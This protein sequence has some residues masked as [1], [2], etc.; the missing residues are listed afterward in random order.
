MTTTA[1]VVKSID[2]T[3]RRLAAE[4]SMAV[5]NAT[6]Q[7]EDRI[8]KALNP[9]LLKAAIKEAWKMFED[10]KAKAAEDLDRMASNLGVGTNEMRANMERRFAERFQNLRLAEATLRNTEQSSAAD[11]KVFPW[12]INTAATYLETALID[13]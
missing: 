4:R 2:V 9:K 5:F 13:N 10:E 8:E 11:R 7:I 3:A 1:T 6:F 12:G